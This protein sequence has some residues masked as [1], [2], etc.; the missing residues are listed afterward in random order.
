MKYQHGQLKS[1]QWAVF[2]GRR[3]FVNSVT[4]DE[5]EAHKDAIIRS[6]HWYKEQIEKC[7]AEMEKNG[8]LDGSD[9]SS[10]CFSDYMS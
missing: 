4:D 3:Y 5:Q 2:T 10:T 8:F 1:G 6:A 9:G 7:E